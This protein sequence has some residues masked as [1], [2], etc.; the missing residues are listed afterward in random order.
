MTNASRECF[1]TALLLA[2]AGS[3]CVICDQP[4]VATFLFLLTVVAGYMGYS[5]WNVK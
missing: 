1:V 2:L 3:L 4:W 5:F